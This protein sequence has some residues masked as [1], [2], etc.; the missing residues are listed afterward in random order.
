MAENILVGVLT[1]IALASWIWVFWLET[2]GIKKKNIN[3][4]KDKNN[5][6]VRG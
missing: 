5:D 6:E 1:I 3:N 4:K 2:G